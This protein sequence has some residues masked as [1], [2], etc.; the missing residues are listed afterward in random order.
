MF[1]KFYENVNLLDTVQQYLAKVES[2]GFMLLMHQ[3][4]DQTAQK[5]L[6]NHEDFGNPSAGGVH[7]TTAFTNN[8]TLRNLIETM[9]KAFAARNK[10]D[11]EGYAYNAVG[12][13]HKGSNAIVVIAI[14]KKMNI[15]RIEDIDD[16]LLD[17][18][19]AGKIKGF[20]IPNNYIVGYWRADGQF[21]ANGRFKPQ[22]LL[23]S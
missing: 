16:K 15:R 11:E 10:G 2:A 7:G 9:Q 12:R 4:H 21:F 17:L 20:A 13:M 19:M 5:I 8:Q 22:G 14:P 6:A 23:E 1:R 18:Q 3:T